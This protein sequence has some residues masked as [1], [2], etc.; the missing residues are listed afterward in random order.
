MQSCYVSMFVLQPFSVVCQSAVEGGWLR[1]AQPSVSAEGR[2]QAGRQGCAR[3]TGEHGEGGLGQGAAR[4]TA[5]AW[6][7]AP[8]SQ[9]GAEQSRAEQSRAEPREHR[10]TE[11][12]REEPSHSPGM[13]TRLLV[14]GMPVGIPCSLIQLSQV[15]GQ[16]TIRDAAQQRRGKA[17]NKQHGQHAT[18]TPHTQRCREGRRGERGRGSASEGGSTGRR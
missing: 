9:T 1:A 11:A 13:E 16:Q 17:E 6:A 7:E 14:S 2:E 5:A 8:N 4:E 15:R 18:S 12:C 10:G 3:G